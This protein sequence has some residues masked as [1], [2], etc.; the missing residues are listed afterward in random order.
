MIQI[1]DQDPHFPGTLTLKVGLEPQPITQLRKPSRSQGI[2][3]HLIHLEVGH[4]HSPE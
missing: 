1:Q 4:Q 2:A 3:F